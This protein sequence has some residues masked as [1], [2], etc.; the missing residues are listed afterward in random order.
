MDRNRFGK[1][2]DALSQL[3]QVTFIRHHRN[4]NANESTSGRCYW[5][6]EYGKNAGHWTW[7]W[8]RNFID[9]VFW[10]DRR[11]LKRHCEL[12]EIRDYHRALATVKRY[13]SSKK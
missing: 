7:R 5:E 10:W 3:F 4:S 8:A 1:I 13:E 6:S 9:T 2:T 11:G 12:S